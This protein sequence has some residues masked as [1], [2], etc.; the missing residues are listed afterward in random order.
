MLSGLKKILK[1]GVV[2]DPKGA[3]VGS[4]RVKRSLK[5][6]SSEARRS[7]KSMG[8]DFDGL[9]TRIV[10]AFTLGAAVAALRSTINA[11]KDLE[12]GLANVAKTTG[13]VDVEID[14]LR[15]NVVEL[16][17]DIPIATKGFLEVAAAAGALGIKG[18]RDVTAFTKSV[19][20]L[21]AVTDIQGEEGGKQ[22]AR[23]LSILNEPISSI[24][25]FA[26][27]I[28]FLGSNAAATESEILS[29]TTELTK[30]TGTFGVSSKEVLALS[31]AMVSLGQAP[32]LAATGIGR[33]FRVINESL[34]EGGANAEKLERIMGRSAQSIKDSFQEDS[35]RT[36]TEFLGKVN[37]TGENAGL[38]LDSLGISGDRLARV[39]IPLTNNLDS[40]SD[41][42]DVVARSAGSMAIELDRFANTYEGKMQTL[43]NRVNSL[44]SAIGSGL[45]PI[46]S[47]SVHEIS[48]M[49]DVM[50]VELLTTEQ[51]FQ[52]FG[53]KVLAGLE[54]VG[55]SILRFFVPIIVSVITN[56]GAAMVKAATMIE[57]GFGRVFV[58][59]ADKAEKFVNGIIGA[60]NKV[61]PGEGLDSVKFGEGMEKR[62]KEL[63][64]TAT[65]S[66]ATIR[67][68]FAKTSGFEADKLLDSLDANSNTAKRLL[69][70]RL[71]IA[72]ES[73]AIKKEE[74]DLAQAE[75]DRMI[76]IGRK[77][78]EERL[79]KRVDQGEQDAAGKALL[80]QLGDIEKK[81]KEGGKAG[82]KR[83]RNMRDARDAA[84][85]Y[86]Q[87]LEAASLLSLRDLAFDGGGFD[88][89]KLRDASEE[90]EILTSVLEDKLRRGVISTEDAFR[91]GATEAVNEFANQ[92]QNAFDLA[93]AAV[94]DFGRGFASATV[95][96][97]TGAASIEEAFGE[98]AKGILANLAEMIIQQQVFNMIA[99]LTGFGGNSFSVTRAAGSQ[100]GIPIVAATVL[101]DGGVV[102]RDGG[103]RGGFI[104]NLGA[105]EVPAILERGET[106]L[107]KGMGGRGNSVVINLTN[108]ITI[109][110]GGSKNASGAMQDSGFNPAELG[111]RIGDI[112]V[113]KINEML[114]DPSHPLYQS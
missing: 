98:M 8:D 30:A 51:K 36:V 42:Q 75:I 54:N 46:L 97:L 71:E 22:I 99:G 102:G 32:E 19:A 113:A 12:T 1:L 77:A 59:V 108:A 103:S 82:E 63:E 114:Q 4:Q 14:Q 112:T 24:G 15:S 67:D 52:L 49:F 81:E 44:K 85:E 76:E 64:A 95:D 106:V 62:V 105:N 41:A 70:E 66:F 2:I 93:N 45:L 61:T 48:R 87:S 111:E 86:Y 55:D 69:E 43:E 3:E 94:G 90:L 80:D 78:D 107:P 10:Q 28:N 109:E 73:L 35:F 83:V 37:D 40:V 110:G 58:A 53:L 50:S 11:A 79:K 33:V 89:N 16:G 72:E 104:G 17:K 96:A 34:I 26:D 6:M 101:H 100:N 27:A 84:Y 5:D 47:D 60:L 74:D 91:F 56:V 29:M 9:R 25:E 7:T 13:M 57:L 20:S 31:T 38:V 23:I 68:E 88:A 21:A 39:L 18:V 92:S 65:K